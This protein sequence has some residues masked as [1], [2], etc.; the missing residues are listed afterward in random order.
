L[1]G[2]ADACPL[3]SWRRLAARA[4]LATLPALGACATGN[5][6]AEDSTASTSGRLPVP[7]WLPRSRPPSDER[8]PWL[9]T[10][11]AEIERIRLPD[12]GFRDSLG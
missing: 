8:P 12:D 10:L 5:R 9:P 11:P 2:R 7:G 6:T 1:S 4:L 3:P